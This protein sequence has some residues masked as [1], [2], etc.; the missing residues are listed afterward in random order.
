MPE[1]KRS[2]SRCW[3]LSLWPGKASA[4]PPDCGSFIAGAALR[5]ARFLAAGLMLAVLVCPRADAADPLRPPG[6]PHHHL[7]NF[8]GRPLPPIAIHAAAMGY[9]LALTGSPDL[10]RRYGLQEILVRNARIAP[11]R[12]FFNQKTGQKEIIYYSAGSK[13]GSDL[14]HFAARA[15]I[16]RGVGRRYPLT[17]EDIAVL[18]F[19]AAQRMPFGVDPQAEL[20]LDTITRYFKT[21]WKLTDGDWVGVHLYANFSNRAYVRE[22]AQLTIENTDWRQYGAVFFD[23]FVGE[24][25]FQPVNGG[26]DPYPDWRTGQIDY[27]RRVSEVVRDPARTG[28]PG[29]VAVFA[30][31][32]SATDPQVIDRYHRLNRDGQILLDHVYFE[33][34]D[35]FDDARKQDRINWDVGRQ[36]PNGTVPGTTQPAFVD[37]RNPNRFIPANVV[38]VDDVYG[39]LPKGLDIGGNYERNA[40]FDQH[41]SACGNAGR[42]G[43]WFGWYGADTVD[44]TDRAG[45]Q[46]FTP[47]LQLLRAIPNWDNIA[48]IPVPPFGQHGPHRHWDGAVY[49][50]TNSFASRQL[51]YAI[52]P[53]NNELYAVFRTMEAELPLPPD[54]TI[55][56]AIR[57]GRYF[58]RPGRAHSVMNDLTIA[59]GTITLNNPDLVGRGLRCGLDQD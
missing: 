5:P 6:W 18:T 59:S 25:D 7:H 37:P 3:P 20:T 4:V 40:H 13:S 33:R 43:M 51:I 21:A 12:V 41:L 57:A 28:A 55:E 47:D 53:I 15:G 14:S 9:G 26:Q 22:A 35:R 17:Q 1:P 52:N 46:V 45:R 39:F 32:W 2:G 24:P 19:V 58:E 30:N 38:S 8:T 48:G 50:S 23:S 56:D 34:G 16:E 10:A 36:N 54:T 29:P 49:R 27:V 44:L 31:V 11:V 42:Y